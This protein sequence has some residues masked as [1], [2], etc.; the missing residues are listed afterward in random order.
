[1]IMPTCGRVAMGQC[2][3]SPKKPTSS[4]SPEGRQKAFFFFEVIT[5][6]F[7]YL[8]TQHEGS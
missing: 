2:A 6:L 4:P 5:L 1:M 8:A 7:I 3:N